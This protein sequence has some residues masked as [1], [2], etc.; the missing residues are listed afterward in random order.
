MLGH[1]PRTVIAA[2][3]LP[4]LLSHHHGVSEAIPILQACSTNRNIRNTTRSIQLR[5]SAQSIADGVKIKNAFLGVSGTHQNFIDFGGA[6]DP[7]GAANCMDPTLHN[8]DTFTPD[9]NTPICNWPVVS[10]QNWAVE[11]IVLWVT[12]DTGETTHP[13]APMA[14]NLVPAELPSTLR[15]FEVWEMPSWTAD[16]PLTEFP[17]GLWSLTLVNVAWGGSELQNILSTYEE[18]YLLH[19]ENTRHSGPITEFPFNSLSSPLYSWRLSWLPYLDEGEF[20]DLRMINVH[21][22]HLHT[23]Y[24]YYVK[25]VG[26]FNLRNIDFMMPALWDLSI[27]GNKLES[28]TAFDVFKKMPS[29]VK[30]IDIH[31]NGITGSLDWNTVFQATDGPI[32]MDFS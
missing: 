7:C 28:S 24:F 10:C 26:S 16:V 5:D 22:P 31:S 32:Y 8:Q 20:P 13:A 21:Y 4:G 23:L 17:V 25:R 29:T 9:S 18:L 6:V 1:L 27:A 19:I 30:Y 2:L 3:G 14:G 11:Q 12:A 15:V